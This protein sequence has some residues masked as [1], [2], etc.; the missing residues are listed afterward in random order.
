[1]TD[2]RSDS[3]DAPEENEQGLTDRFGRVH[4]Y[5]RVS[6]TDRCNMRCTYCMPP[7]GIDLNSKDHVL[8]YEELLRVVRVGASLGIRKVRVTGGEP[9]VRKGLAGFLKQLS[10]VSALDTL[11]LTTNGLFLPQKLEELRET[12]LSKINV[13]LDSLD[14]ER[15]ARITRGASLDRV[16]DALE[17]AVE[18]GFHVKVNAVALPDLTLD[19][20]G[21]F[22]DLARRLDV[23]VR[24]IEFMPL[25]GSAWQSDQ[26]MPLSELKEEVVSH[27]DLA[28]EAHRGVST[29]YR[30]GPDEPGRIGFIASLTGPFCEECSRLRLTSNGVLRPCLFQETGVPLRP[31]LRDGGTDAQIA[32]RFHAALDEKWTGNPAYRGE[33]RPTEKN[34]PQDFGQIRSIGG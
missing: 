5:L 11:A 13:S 27:F 21:S 12:H 9:G 19:E 6:V 8:S 30:L 20:I 17:V 10:G 18:A 24:S 23:E 33:W 31:L 7:E 25:C 14:A 29:T 26:F 1:M 3:P 32:E 4:D 2:P 28:S 34:P 22:V 15:F 16:L